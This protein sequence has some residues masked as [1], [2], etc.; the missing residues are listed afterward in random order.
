MLWWY[1]E[2]PLCA[3][4]DTTHGKCTESLFRPD[5]KN[6]MCEYF[7]EQKEGE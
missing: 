4:L 5:A 3:N 6:G 7:K 1:I 2:C